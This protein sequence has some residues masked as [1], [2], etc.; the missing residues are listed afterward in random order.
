MRL[1][2]FSDYALRTLIYLNRV[3]SL[4][5]LTQISENLNIPKNHLNMVAH[6]LVKLGYIKSTRGRF[7]GLQ[8][9]DHAG[10]LRVG[11]ILRKTENKIR[12]VECFQDQVNCPLFPK[13]KFKKS[14]NKAI[15][16]FFSSLNE[17][18]LDEIS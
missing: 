2:D 16:A 8:I 7:G 3:D 17:L 4:V 12:L 5:T 15:E 13:C 18:T 11:E 9:E 6:K 14:L 10:S 1:T